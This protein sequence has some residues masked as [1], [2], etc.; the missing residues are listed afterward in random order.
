MVAADYA[1]VQ[2]LCD[3]AL[4]MDFLSPAPANSTPSP[5]RVDDHPSLR[6][7]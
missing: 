1:Y 4:L 2:L 6:T 3:E 5:W 7:Q